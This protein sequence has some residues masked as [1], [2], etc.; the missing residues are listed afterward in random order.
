MP[1]SSKWFFP[2]VFSTKTL[3]APLFSPIRSTCPAYL[4]VLNLTTWTILGMYRSFSSSLCRFLHSP[5]T[6][7][8]L[9]PNILLSTL[10]LKTLNLHSSLSVSAHVH[11]HIINR[12]NYSSVYFNIHNFA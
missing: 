2:S 12:Q 4:I 7:S 3:Y 10:F 8:L 9:G 6:S 11:T 1:R 5:V